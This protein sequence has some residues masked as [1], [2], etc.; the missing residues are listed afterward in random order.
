MIIR[1]VSQWWALHSLGIDLKSC[2]G[3]GGG[4]HCSAE[5]NKEFIWCTVRT[6]MSSKHRF[7]L[8]LAIRSNENL[9]QSYGILK[10]QSAHITSESSSSFVSEA[11]REQKTC[12]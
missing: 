5:L 2:L 12:L 4:R 9:N 10:K 7:P 8:V 6:A 3:Q 1:L 11:Q